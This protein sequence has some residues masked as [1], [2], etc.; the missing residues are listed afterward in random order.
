MSKLQQKIFSGIVTEVDKTD[1]KETNAVH[2]ENVDISIVGKL[3]RVDGIEKQITTGLGYQIDGIFR[4][5][6][7]NFALYNGTLATF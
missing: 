6:S 5:N 2:A 7:T 3:K 1:M 4:I